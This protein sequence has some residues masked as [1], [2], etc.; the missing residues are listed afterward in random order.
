MRQCNKADG[1]CA[2]CSSFHRTYSFTPT[3]GIPPIRKRITRS[4]LTAWEVP[5]KGGARSRR[6]RAEDIRASPC[7]GLAGRQ[8]SSS[9]NAASRSRRNIPPRSLPLRNP[10]LQPPPPVPAPQQHIQVSPEAAHRRSTGIP[11]E[12]GRTCCPRWPDRPASCT[13]GRN[14]MCLCQASGAWVWARKASRSAAWPRIGGRSGQCSTASGVQ[15]SMKTS[16][17]PSSR[18]W[19]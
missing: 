4:Y 15:Q 2:V 16:S 18:L 7:P 14:S 17:R 9:A 13:R 10:L 5:V 6:R 1:R 8:P 12:A 19:P 11:V 3:Q